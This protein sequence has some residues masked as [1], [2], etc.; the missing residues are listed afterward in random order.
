MNF[1]SLIYPYRK[2]IVAAFAILIAFGLGFYRGRVTAPEKIIEKE[3]PVE[4]IVTQTK[5]V[6]DIRY[7]PKVTTADPDVDIK[8]PKQQLTVSVNG[9]QQTIKKSDSEKYVFD[10]GQL[11][12]EQNSKASLDITIPTV[13][14]TRKWSI[15]IGASRNGAAYLVRAPLK[16]HV[17]A[18]AAAD[19]KSVM[20]GIS[21]DF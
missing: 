10:K 19:K 4:H 20:G 17:G 8:I 13:D 14:K 15:G 21:F 7:V 3:V 11:K 6:T 9:Q 16:G 5:T 2:Y 18:W 1:L 12:L